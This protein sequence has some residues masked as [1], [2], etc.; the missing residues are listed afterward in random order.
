MASILYLDQSGQLGG[1]ELMLAEIAR[2]VGAPAHVILFDDGPFVAFLEQLGV[3]VQVERARLG[4]T[5]SGGW[6]ASANAVPALL[7]QV[8]T[9]VRHARRF[10]LIYANTAKALV[11]GALAAA[12]LRKPLV[13]HLHDILDES[14]FSRMNIRVLTSLARRFATRVIA[15]SQATAD[16]FVAAKGDRSRVDVIY[17]GFA[18]AP[19]LAD[20]SDKRVATRSLLE[21]ESNSFVTIVVGRIARWKGQQVLLEAARSQ[22][23]WTVWI[24]GD[25]LFTEE[26]MQYKRELKEIASSDD[27]VGRVKFCGFREDLPALYAAADVV[28]HCSTAPEPFG[29]VIVEAMLSARPVVASNAGGAKEI[30]RSDAIGWL[31]APGDVDALRETLLEIKRNPGLADLRAQAGRS[32]ALSRFSIGTI[33][34]QIRTLVEKCVS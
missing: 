14:H 34:G 2:Q 21:T 1:A 33:L 6:F 16:A 28:V 23:D 20:Q 24:V 30:I 19:F 11:V 26:D 8:R 27:L 22:K 31:V 3:S 7:Q 13:Y 10:D 32:D 5:K 18:I 9:I 15:N 25:A 29:R 12:Y 4:V 17:N